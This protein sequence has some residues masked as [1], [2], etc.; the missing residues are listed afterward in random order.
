MTD[1]TTPQKILIHSLGQAVGAALA[2]FGQLP[3]ALAAVGRHP[4]DSTIR[5]P[6]IAIVRELAHP[7]PIR[8]ANLDSGSPIAIT[9]PALPL[10]FG[11]AFGFILRG[12]T[13]RLGLISCAVNQRMVVLGILYGHILRNPVAELVDAIRGDFAIDLRKMNRLLDAGLREAGTSIDELWLVTTNLG[14]PILEVLEQYLP[15]RGGVIDLRET[16][17]GTV[18]V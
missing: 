7:D 12:K 15:L 4:P 16:L 6:S 8:L 17:R 11:P 13:T 3:P 5:N 9:P 18:D 2:G 1:P 14:V 10:A